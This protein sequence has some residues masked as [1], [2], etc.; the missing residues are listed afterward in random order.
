M[1][2]FEIFF[3]II[4]GWRSVFCKSSSF[5]TAVLHALYGLNI[6][7]RKTITSI[8]RSLEQEHD[9]W[10]RHY[11][12]YS[13][14]TWNHND[15]FRPIITGSLKYFGDDHVQVVADYIS[16]K[17][18][19]K[20][21]PDTSLVRDPMSPKFRHNLMLGMTFL[22]FSTSLPLYK[23]SSYPARSLPI[24]WHRMPKMKK[25]FKNAPNEDLEKY[26]KFQKE[27]NRSKI[28]VEQ[29]RYLRK[30]Y[31]TLGCK[32]KIITALDGDFCNRTVLTSDIEGVEYVVRARKNIKLCFKHEGEGR[33]FY[34]KEKF[35]PEQKRQDESIPW[36]SCIIFHGG[37]FRNVDYKEVSGVYWQ[38]GAK[39]K[40]LRLIVLR[41]IPYRRTKKGKL[42]YRQPGYLLCTDLFIDIEKVIQIYFDR[43]EIEVNHKDQ[44]HFLGIGQ[45]QVRNKKG[46]EKQP[47]L[48]VTAY[49]ALLFAGIQL[50]EKNP[51]ED[52][53]E[54]T[55]W[56]K[57]KRR[58]SIRDL[59]KRLIK[60]LEKISDESNMKVSSFIEALVAA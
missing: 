14:A 25:P 20:H 49:S 47:G 21:I 41:P 28:F 7:H 3:L 42:L 57:R 55:S 2:L 30:E 48:L 51:E 34:S 27:N 18:S 56:Y 19:G 36:K 11:K 8:I 1:S 43:W 5:V 38:G 33:R 53:S 58:P 15:L 22:H 45:A 46:V 29:M 13:R 23:Q 52:L 10:S 35:N 32:K 44:K 50:I 24:H 4:S 59:S 37:E 40:E 60:E 39:R 54:K 6:N 12:L 9:D 31:N 16:I 26:K 17:K